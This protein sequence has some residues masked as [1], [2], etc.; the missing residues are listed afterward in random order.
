MW[1]LNIIV[2][3]ATAVLAG[4]GVG[5]GGLLVIYLTLV[6]NLPQLQA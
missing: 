1:I 5:G 2:G 6:L 3:A 4:L